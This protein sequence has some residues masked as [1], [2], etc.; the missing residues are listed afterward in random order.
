MVGAGLVARVVGAVAISG[1]DEWRAALRVGLAVMFVFTGLTHF[2]RLRGDFVQMV[3]P[4]LPKPA[5]LVAITGVAEIVGGVGLLVGPT[6]AA[7]S[8]ALA[9]LLVVMAPA[10][11]HAARTG[12]TIGG[13][14]AMPVAWR[15]LLQAVWI[16]LL[17]WVGRWFR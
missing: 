14:P 5:L 3:P 17:L 6:V 7:G 2:G 16:V 4:W 9:V 1:L 8:L 10:N 13:R 12:M 15:L 11:V